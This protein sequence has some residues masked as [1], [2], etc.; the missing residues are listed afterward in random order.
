MYSANWADPAAAL[1]FPIIILTIAAEKFARKVEEDSFLEAL[2]LYGQTLIVTVACFL[3]LSSVSIQNFVITFPEILITIGG[4]TVL[5]GKWIGLRL[6]E[7]NRFYKLS[8]E[9][10][11]VS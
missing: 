3:I 9:V 7:Y 4:I 5:L 8:S 1:F 2:K 10:A 6:T 11:Y